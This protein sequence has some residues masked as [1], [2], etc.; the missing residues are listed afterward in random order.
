M[1]NKRKGFTLVELLVV[2]AILA[3]LATVSVVGYTAFITRANVSADET[4]ATQINT[5]LHAY[6]NDH[7]SEHYG[8]QIT[9]DN[10]REITKKILQTSE[11]NELVPKTD[12]YHFYFEFDGKGSGKYVVKSDKEVI[13]ASGLNAL[14]G[15]IRAGALDVNS[16]YL[17][18]CFTE[19]GKYF[20]VDTAGS[21]LADVING[22]YTMNDATNLEDI[23]AK[24]DALNIA[25][26]SAFV[27]SCV[28]VTDDAN[29]RVSN[30]P[31]AVVFVDGVT[32]IGTTTKAWNGTGWS[33]TSADKLAAITGELTIP[34]TVKFIAGDS[35]LIGSSATVVINK[36][37]AEVGKMA[38][39]HFTDAKIQTKTGVY[40]N[41]TCTCGNADHANKSVIVSVSDASVEVLLNY[42]NPAESF[43]AKV[44]DVANKVLNRNNYAFVVYDNKTFDLNAFNFV[45]KNSNLPSSTMNSDVAWTVHGG[46]HAY[47]KS[48]TRDGIVTLAD[49]APTTACDITFVGTT[50]EGTI[51]TFVLKVVAAN[52]LKFS[53]D[54]VDMTTRDS[55]SLFYG[56]TADSSNTFALSNIDIQYNY[57]KSEIEGLD[58]EDEV[59]FSEYEDL[60]TANGQTLSVKSDDASGKLAIKVNVG[61]YYSRTINVDLMNVNNLNFVEKHKNTP[62]VDNDKV[63][64][65]GDNNA[66]LLG[67]LFIQKKEYPVGAQVWVVKDMPSAD[68]STMAGVFE[69][70]MIDVAKINLADDASK[71]EIQF[72]SNGDVAIVVV[73]APDADGNYYRISEPV[74]VNVVDA[75]NI[76]SYGTTTSTGNDELKK[77]ITITGGNPCPNPVTGS[78][79]LLNNIAVDSAVVGCFSI[80]NGNTLY[81]NCFTINVEKGVL[82]GHWGIISLNNATMQDTRVIGA[83]YPT[84]AISA[85]DLY[86]TNAVHAIGTSTID[87]CYIA[88]CRAPLAS[89]YEDNNAADVVTVRNSVL[90]GGRYANVDIRGGTL[91]FE[92]NVIAVNQPHTDNANA[93]SVALNKKVAGLGITVWLEAP[94]GTNIQG[95]ANI[96]Q[97]N[98]IPETYND[99]P[100]VSISASG[101]TVSADLND[102]FNTIFNE[103]QRG[104]L[105]CTDSHRRHNDNCYTK[106]YKNA[107]FHFGTGTRYINTGVL[108]EDAGSFGSIAS[109][110]GITFPSGD[111]T[112]L[113][114]SVPAGYGRLEL[115]MSPD[116]EGAGALGGLAGMLAKMKMH[117]YGV[118]NTQQD[119]FIAS[120]NAE[121]IYSPW[122][123]TAGGVTYVEYGFTNGVIIPQ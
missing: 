8:Q 40:K 17:G 121:Y 56:K 50:P 111:R 20:F 113:G 71:T 98:F 92:G 35:L 73:V 19:G 123:Q 44:E 55:I 103:T 109:S 105:I 48:V 85:M 74:R 80:T 82:Q 76:R 29:Y 96:V 36:T 21:D 102:L 67:D 13:N 101:I 37:A 23:L 83:L 32:A 69:S 12:G 16:S 18:S 84:V 104:E 87:N 100:V 63:L 45:G 31:E 97:Y 10:V 116:I 78:I 86:G 94:S 4:V 64:Y 38:F 11:L 75:T 122:T 28:V 72:T 108:C 95:M 30:A 68:Y 53:F 47:V 91:K 34:N 70:T 61:E 110:M 81:G 59:F 90:Y 106:V 77:Y 118:Q 7:T 14:I 114:S 88:N 5:F 57:P 115:S 22:L 120:Q 93:D 24:L 107:G 52:G 33:V 27:R 9:E 66:V 6:M 43:S 79:V 15:A 2:I 25:K 99:I 41:G 62:Y 42:Y 46:T 58:L 65:V 89:G 60:F 26:L 3:I 112:G 49:N 119:M 117:V 39:Q 1:N 51:T 54:G